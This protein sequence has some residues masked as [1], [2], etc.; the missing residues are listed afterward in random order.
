MDNKPFKIVL[1]ALLSAMTAVSA[2]GCLITGFDLKI[3]Q[4]PMVVMVAGLFALIGAIG[5]SF[6]YGGAVVLGVTAMASLFFWSG[7]EAQTQTQALITRISYTYDQAYQWGVIRFPGAW[8]GVKADLPMVIAAALIALIVTWVVCRRGP[9]VLALLA[10]FSMLLQCLV[11]TDTTPNGACLFFLL[12]S[13]VTFPR[14]LRAE[15]FCR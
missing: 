1:A 3:E 5:F 9:T 2:V 8:Y 6:R 13:M 12:V 11:V 7:G 15:R 4:V 10:A 14:T